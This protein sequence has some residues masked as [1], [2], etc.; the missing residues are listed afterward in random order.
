MNFNS[1]NT[2]N[3]IFIE[4]FGIINCNQSNYLG[5]NTLR[6]SKSKETQWL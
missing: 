1:T 2:T 3:N 6:K 4:Q 5:N